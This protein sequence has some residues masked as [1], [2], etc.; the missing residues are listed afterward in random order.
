MPVEFVN[1]GTHIPVDIV[2]RSDPWNISYDGKHPNDRILKTFRTIGESLWPSIVKSGLGGNTYS[3]CI[4]TSCVIK[5]FLKRKGYEWEIVPA[6]V[7]VSLK[8]YEGDLAAPLTLGIGEPNE[9]MGVQGLHVICVFV[10]ESGRKWVIDGSIRQAWRAKYWGRPP[11][12]IIAEAYES[13]PVVGPDDPF[14]AKGFHPI[15]GTSV[16]YR[17]G[18]KLD[19]FWLTNSSYPDYWNGTPD[20]APQRSNQICDLLDAAWRRTKSPRLE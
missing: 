5:N 20:A 1:T 8:N 17:N 7:D 6:I 11:E 12:V 9:D 19:L 3:R 10:D 2:D 14:K 4:L 15:A 18:T 13:P 16:D